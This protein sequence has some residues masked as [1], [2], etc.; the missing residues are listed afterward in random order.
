MVQTKSEHAKHWFSND[1][2]FRILSL[3]C[4]QTCVHEKNKKI[5]LNE[6]F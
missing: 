2:K 3:V 1:L 6:N 5:F 4:H